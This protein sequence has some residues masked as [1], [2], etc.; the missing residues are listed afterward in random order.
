[1]FDKLKNIKFGKSKDNP[2]KLL[3]KVLNKKIK[4]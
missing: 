1:M 4:K 2:Q 3:T